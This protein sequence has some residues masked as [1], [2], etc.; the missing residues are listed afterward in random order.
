[1]KDA[2]PKETTAPARAVSTT[3]IETRPASDEI[4]VVKKG[5]L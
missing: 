4:G 3:M 5:R 1:L 2:D